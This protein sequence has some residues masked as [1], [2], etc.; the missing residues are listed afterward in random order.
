M[1]ARVLDIPGDRPTDARGLACLMREVVGTTLAGDRPR[2]PILVATRQLARGQNRGS[3]YVVSTHRTIIEVFHRDGMPEELIEYRF[4]LGPEVRT[5]VTAPPRRLTILRDRGLMTRHLL[6]LAEALETS[7]DGDDPGLAA[8]VDRFD[9]LCRLAAAQ[10]A[11]IAC[12]DPLGGDP[13]HLVRPVATDCPGPLEPATTRFAETSTTELATTPFFRRTCSSRTGPLLTHRVSGEDGRE[14][15]DELRPLRCWTVAD[16][17]DP[18]SMLRMT[19]D[20]R[21]KAD[22]PPLVTWRRSTR[23]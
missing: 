12:D 11:Q 9:A 10:A 22:G 18:V 20:A 4:C 2:H 7:T 19:S 6:D 16:P 17:V 23:R 21:L 3:G 14:P 13:I 5:L 15:V 1:V 8:R